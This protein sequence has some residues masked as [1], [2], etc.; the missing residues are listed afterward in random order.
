MMIEVK[1]IAPGFDLPMQTG[2]KVKL[3]SLLERHSALVLVFYLLDF[4]GE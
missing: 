3:E 1:D 2:E 4:S